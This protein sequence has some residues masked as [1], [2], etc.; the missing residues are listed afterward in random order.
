LGEVRLREVV[1]WH[2][3]SSHLLLRVCG[4]LKKR[5]VGT[6]LESFMIM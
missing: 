3:I 6:K 1:P 2:S 4:L 5:V